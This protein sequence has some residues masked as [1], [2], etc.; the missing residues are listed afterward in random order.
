MPRD[1]RNLGQIT[2]YSVERQITS[3]PYGHILTNAA[4]WSPDGKWI[5]YDVRSD[6]SGSLFDG[7][8]I[9]RVNVETGEVQVLYEART[10][11]MSAWRRAVRS[12]TASSSSTD[13]NTQRQIG[14][15]RRHTDKE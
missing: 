5:V 11:R 13:R 15:I 1:D 7:T 6:P 8:R 3:S 10:I 2:E 12:T 14:H 4:V 9:E